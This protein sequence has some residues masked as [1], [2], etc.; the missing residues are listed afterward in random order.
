MG[1]YL[2]TFGVLLLC[3]QYRALA[4]R[5]Q[6]SQDPLTGLLNRR[7]FMDHC[8]TMARQGALVVLDLDDF[9]Q[10]N[11]SPRSR[12]RGQGAGGGGSLSCRPAGSGGQPLRR[13][14]VCAAIAR[15]GPLAQQARCEQIRQGIETL[16]LKGSG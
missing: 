13:G 11:R 4:L 7:G 5:R 16:E 15:A 1:N 8:V 9:K 14:R 12:D 10:I 3:T 6:A 2:S